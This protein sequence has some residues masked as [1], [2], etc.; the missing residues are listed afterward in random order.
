MKSWKAK[1]LYLLWGCGLMM[2]FFIFSG[3]I[4]SWYLPKILRLSPGQ[5]MMISVH[6]PL[7]FYSKVRNDR[8]PLLVEVPKQQPQ[9]TNHL[10]L[11][12]RR[13]EHYNIQLRMFGMIPVKQLRVEVA[14]P[15]MVIPGGQAIGVLLSSH[16]V[17]V[18]GHLPVKG[19]DH[20]QY[21]PA[22]DAGIKVGDILLAIDGNP[23]NR[24]DELEKFLKNV[25]SSG[26]VFYLSVKRY[27]KI[28]SIRIKPVLCYADEEKLT[29]K[30]M[31]G[32]FI[33]DPAAG[34]GTLTFYDPVTHRFAGL[35]H[36]IAEFSGNKGIPFQSGEIVFANICGIKAGT[37]GQPGEKI[38][39][40]NSYQNSVG[41]ID[42]NCRFGIYG[43]FNEHFAD[44]SLAQP[45][46]VAYSSQIKLGPAEIYTVI[47]GT[48]VERFQ[49]EIVRVYRQDNPQDKG[50]IIKVT[51]PEL[52]KQ[53]GGIIQGMSGSPI[54][55]DGKLIGAVTH[56]FVN[57][58]TRGYG[59]LAEWMI[60]E[61]NGSNVND[62]KA[63]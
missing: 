47:K 49:V 22:R 58:P 25:K 12:S 55:Q 45:L 1:L 23:V 24:A 6:Y 52:L 18:V 9:V 33:E 38:G 30:Y 60:N 63:S 19:V 37:P 50:M 57:D 21:Y 61:I 20:Q 3:M 27:G 54:V 62:L 29:K 4:Q 42:K 46:P 32:I 28:V 44:R 8:D 17:V 14:E 31:L 5:K 39:V 35:G 26:K 11:N 51:D 34:I 40:F 36:R 53:T 41:K 7:S 56:V 2:I 15:A 59:V 16:G 13:K 10:I 48:G 43:T